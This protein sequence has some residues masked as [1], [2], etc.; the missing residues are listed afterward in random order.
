M[1]LQAQIKWVTNIADF[2]KAIEEGT[3]GVVAHTAKVDQ[4]TRSLSGNGLLGAANNYIAAVE[5]MGGVEKLTAAEKERING[6][7]VKALDKYQALGREAPDALT[8]LA[9]ATAK[10]EPPLS[11]ADR[12]A[13]LLKSTFGQFTLANLAASAIQKLTS[14][15]GDF[16]DTGMKLPAVEQSYRRLTDSMKIDGQVMLA[17]MTTSTKG[18]VGNY[19]LMASANKA[20]LLGLPVTAD[21]MGE[22]AKTATILGRAMGQD[23]TKSLDDLITALGRSSPLILDNL[24]LTVK[25]GEANEAYAAKL[26]KTVEQMTDSEKKM[27]FYLAAMDAARKKT[28]ELGD[29]TMTLGDIA[30]SIWTKIGNSVSSSVATVNVGL[31]SALTSWAS[32]KKFYVDWDNTGSFNAA[33]LL[34]NQRVS[35]S[36]AAAA[37]AADEAKKHAAATTSVTKTV[38]D[39]AKEAEALSTKALSPLSTETRGLILAFD[40][41]G[42]SAAQIA[43]KLKTVT[44]TASVNEEQITRVIDAQ[45]KA[46]TV[47]EAHAKVL[48]ENRRALIPL[49]DEQKKF[50]IDNANLSRGVEVTALKFGISAKAVT[51]YL[52][53]VKNGKE[54][55]EIWR[56]AHEGMLDASTRFINKAVDDWNAGQ[57]KIGDASLKTLAT[58]Y[59]ASVDYREKNYQLTLGGTALTVRQIEIERDAKIKA[60]GDMGGEVSKYYQKQ[61]DLANGTA[62]TI[63]ERMRQ[64]GISTTADLQ[65]QAAA[66]K[67]DYEQMKA[68]G[69]FSAAAVEQAWQKMVD[70]SIAANGGL[71]LSTRDTFKL[72]AQQAQEAFTK[73]GWGGLKD[74]AKQTA[75]DFVTGMVD[76]IP[77]V[78]PMLSKFVAPLAKILGGLFGTAGRDAVIK[79]VTETAGSFDAMHEKLLTLGAA[80]EALWIKLTQGVGR[81]SPEQ[82]KKV[83]D[84]I[85]AA[86][87]TQDAWMQRLP[88]LI[89]KYGLSWEQAGQQAKQAKLDEIA[90]GLIQDFADLTKAGFDVTLVTEKMSKSIN[91]YVQFAVRTGTEIPSAM[92]PLLQKMIEMGL[93][94]TEAG[95]KMTDLEGLSFATT[96]TE[97]FKSIVDAINQLAKALGV[98]PDLIDKIP[99]KTV[100]DVEE[101]YRKTRDT[102]A[103][104]DPTGAT[105]HGGT[106]RVLPFPIIAHNGLLPDEVPA[107]LQTGE[108]VLNRRAAAAVGTQ[109]IG[110][111]NRG[112]RPGGG[113]SLTLQKGAIVVNGAGDPER[114]ADEIMLRLRREKRLKV[115]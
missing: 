72:L 3:G 74:F 4:L 38:A 5:K 59:L 65:K 83:I 102:G 24:G 75:L 99:K 1:T 58:Q 94:T 33:M 104:D 98:I 46:V 89:D 52:D 25:V 111:L 105:F 91:E 73:G 115:A 9:A 90:R 70:Q 28:A 12:A 11:L 56:K 103:D 79:F 57:R 93:L 36:A 88:G 78:G 54:I 43:E 108:A 45:K 30:T 85:N 80:G 37:K 31:G 48:D 53:T 29:Q 49:T 112:D 82:A 71:S 44:S 51:T 21:S 2:K 8:R 14:G 13:G 41:G 35:E 61:I 109:A 100:I 69:Q 87:A 101:R 40:K 39:L 50:A 10:L 19:D 62:S 27:A 16:I 42:L 7:L 55:E 64:Q 17:N 96:L 26:G 20:M 66:A 95:E 86:F 113:G 23:A 47:G 67:R 63:V 34:S 92:K 15:V 60:L 106:A 107:I 18:M 6:I 81:N 114:V 76:A 97:G 32:F 77:V 22:L 110:A 84:E 68:S